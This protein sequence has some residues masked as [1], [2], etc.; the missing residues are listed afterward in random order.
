MVVDHP[1]FG[2]AD[3]TKINLLVIVGVFFIKTRLA[4]HTPLLH[5]PLPLW[6]VVLSDNVFAA[7]PANIRGFRLL[8]HEFPCL[9]YMTVTAEEAFNSPVFTGLVPVT[10]KLLATHSAVYDLLFAKNV[11]V[12]LLAFTATKTYV[13]N[14]LCVNSSTMLYI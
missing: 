9:L 5:L 8:Q 13:A 7:Y 2:I 3:G 1:K 4:K 6:L 12:K 11:Q 10:P 14:R